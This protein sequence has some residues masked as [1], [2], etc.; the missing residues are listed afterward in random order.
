MKLL[1]LEPSDLPE[2][3]SGLCLDALEIANKMLGDVDRDQFAVKFQTILRQVHEHVLKLGPEKIKQPDF[4]MFN[5]F[6]YPQDLEEY[7]ELE[8]GLGFDTV[9][10]KSEFGRFI[11]SSSNK[12]EEKDPFIGALIILRLQELKSAELALKSSYNST[13]R[14]NISNLIKELEGQLNKLVRLIKTKEPAVKYIREA[15]QRRKGAFKGGIAKS[16]RNADLKNIAI[17]EYQTNFSNLSAAEAARRIFD[18]LKKTSAWL[19]DKEGKPLLKDPVNRF[20]LW[21]REY[22]KRIRNNK[23]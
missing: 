11:S 8:S 18:K 13:D 9:D 3:E 21:I 2:T 15:A 1:N 6:M 23:L 22:K 4:D 17:E 12:D 19:F 16:R 5:L 10:P 20:T 7:K 14:D